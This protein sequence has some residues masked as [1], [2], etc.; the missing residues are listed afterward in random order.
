M[1]IQILANCS[2]CGEQFIF[3]AITGDAVLVKKNYDKIPFLSERKKSEPIHRKLVR[4]P[5]V[6]SIS[7]YNNNFISPDRTDAVVMCEA[8]DTAYWENFDKA[9]KV[10]E[11]FWHDPVGEGGSFE[12]KGE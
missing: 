5:Y 7:V 10:L 6:E 12:K 11:A 1:K 8:C 9:V 2:R 4:H 3:P